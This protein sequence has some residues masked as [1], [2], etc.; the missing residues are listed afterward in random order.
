MRSLLA[1]VVVAV[2]LKNGFAAELSTSQVV[3]SIV[4]SSDV[5]TLMRPDTWKLVRAAAQ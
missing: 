5:T 2:A 1:A 4:V 3:W